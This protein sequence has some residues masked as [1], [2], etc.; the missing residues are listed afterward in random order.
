MKTYRV[1][2]TDEAVGQARAYLWHIAVEQ[3]MPLTAARWWRKADAMIQTLSTIPNRCP[4]APENEHSRYELRMLL[5]DECLFVFHVDEETRSVWVVRFRH[6]K[7][8]P[9]PID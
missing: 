3:E 2:I 8:E 6:G 5:V 9:W 1:V 4:Y 7:Q